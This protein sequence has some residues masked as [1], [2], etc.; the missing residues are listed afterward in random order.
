MSSVPFVGKQRKKDRRSPFAKPQIEDEHQHVKWEYHDF[1]GKYHLRKIKSEFPIPGLTVTRKQKCIAA[2]KNYHRD[3]EQWRVATRKANLSGVGSSTKAEADYLCLSD[4][5]RASQRVI[6]ALAP[7]IDQ[8]EHAFHKFKNWRNPNPKPLVIR[9]FEENE[10][11]IDYRKVLPSRDFRFGIMPRQRQQEIKLV[12]EIRNEYDA[13]AVD[14]LTTDELITKVSGRRAPPPAVRD[15]K[16]RRLTAKYHGRSRFS[17]GRKQRLQIASRQ[18]QQLTRTA[19][20]PSGQELVPVPGNHPRE[21]S[22]LYHSRPSTVST[23][24]FRRRNRF[25]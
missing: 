19:S 6:N 24:E 5:G 23:R 13:K 14:V 22:D 4:T 11:E 15:T 8:R 9:P 10:V 12:N 3:L 20:A 7:A 21:L 17:Q 2:N 18:K 16:T 25:L 1:V